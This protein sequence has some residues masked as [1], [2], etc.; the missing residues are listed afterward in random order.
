MEAAEKAISIIRANV[1]TQSHTTAM[2]D[3]F[4]LLGIATFAVCLSILL[5]MSWKAFKRRRQT[6]S[7]A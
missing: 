7:L 3:A 2:N 5:E 6:D 4:F 1:L